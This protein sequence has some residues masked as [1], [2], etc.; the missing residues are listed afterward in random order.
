MKRIW[1]YIAI[2]LWLGIAGKYIVQRLSVP[3]VSLGEVFEE[4]AFSDMQT[5]VEAYGD[6]GVCY[7]SDEEKTDLVE[8]MAGAIGL[9]SRYKIETI[10]S[11]ELAVTELIKDSINGEVVLKAITEEKKNTDGSIASHQSVY[12]KITAYNNVDCAMDYKELVEGMFDAMG[13]EGNV[14]VNLSGSLE[15]NLNYEQRNALTDSLLKGLNAEVVV[16]NRDTDIFTVYGY[17]QG[18]KQ[19]ISIGGEKINVNIAIGYNELDNTTQVYLSSP[20]S[21]LDY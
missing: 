1:V 19:Y 2:V 5:V 9:D 6:Y 7:L 4:T 8:N 20:V 21:S 12:V 15:G 14:N 3:S 16:E 10:R 11:D 18:I 17:T 13:I